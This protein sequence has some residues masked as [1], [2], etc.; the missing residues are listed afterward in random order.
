[1]HTP[2]VCAASIPA[3]SIIMIR[4][5]RM[6]LTTR[7][8]LRPGAHT[9]I[10]H[11][12]TIRTSTT[13]LPSHGA[14]AGAHPVTHSTLP[15]TH[16]IVPDGI[17]HGAGAAVLTTAGTMDGMAV[18]TTAG[19]EDSPTAVVAGAATVAPTS[20]ADTIPTAHPEA[21]VGTT[22]A[23]EADLPQPVVP[24]PRPMVLATVLRA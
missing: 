3:A 11:G 17:A 7:S 6:I 12:G 20:P 4:T 8:A 10:R 23:G 22:M 24:R 1:M 21:L 16:G 9:T 14:I 2:V 15:I 19:A 13:V 5:S 18:G